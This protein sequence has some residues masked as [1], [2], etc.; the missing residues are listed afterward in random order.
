MTACI[1]SR[2]GWIAQTGSPWCDMA[3]C[4]GIGL[5]CIRASRAGAR[6]KCGR[7]G[8]RT[9]IHRIVDTLGNSRRRILRG[10]EGADVT[11]V[12]GLIDSLGTEAAFDDKGYPVEQL[13]Q[14]CCTAIRDNALTAIRCPNSPSCAPTAGWGNDSQTL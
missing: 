14:L 10:T 7:G 8:L 13:K 3:R 1:S 4:E 5:R 11:Q 12:R 2:C 6:Q 9:K